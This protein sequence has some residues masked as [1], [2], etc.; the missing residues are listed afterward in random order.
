MQGMAAPRVSQPQGQVC[1]CVCGGNQ[2][3]SWGPCKLSH[4]EF[5]QQCVDAHPQ[6]VVEMQLQP[7]CNSLL[8]PSTQGHFWA[9]KWS[10]EAEVQD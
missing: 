5:P 7:G 10:K 2:G 3:Q 6:E 9:H 4:E 8:T 1:V